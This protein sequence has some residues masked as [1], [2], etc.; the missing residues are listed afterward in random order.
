VSGAHR[1]IVETGQSLPL[2]SWVEEQRSLTDAWPYVSPTFLAATES[3]APQFK[4]WHTI[5]RRG[6]GELALLP[7]YILD[8]DPAVDHDPRTYLGWQPGDGQEV[9][10]GVQSCDSATAEVDAWGPDALFPCLLLGSPLGYRTEVSYNFWSRPL[11]AELV[12]QLVSAALKQGIRSIVAPWI[13]DR[14]GNAELGSAL[15]RAGG[16][17]NFW[18]YEDY[19][20]LTAESWPAH[21]ASLPI[22]M[23]QRIV[24][25]ERKATATGIRIHRIDGTDITPHIPRIAELTCLNREKNGGSEQ[26]HHIEQLITSLVNA[27]ADLRAYLAEDGDEI[28]GSC[29]VLRKEHRL[30]PKWAGFDYSQVGD[31]SGLY[32]TLVLNAPVRDALAEGLRSVEFGAGAHQAK[33]LRGCTARGVQTALLLA[34]PQL[35]PDAGRLAAAFGAAR[36]TAFGDSPSRPVNLPLAIATATSCCAPTVTATDSCCST[37]Q[38]T[39]DEVSHR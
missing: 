31:R 25:D 5:A 11:F 32:F 37:D 12:S 4:P 13:P 39:A 36:R 19:L 18:G 38:A 24:A 23:R 22:K 9:C 29:V 1:V 26:P 7:G 20:R 34:D 21:L 3:A 10:C 14:L 15:E 17:V 2:M 30:L 28:V 35:R 6:R 16:S 27:G 33:Q 8:S